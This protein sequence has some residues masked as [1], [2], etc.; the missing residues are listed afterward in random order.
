MSSAQRKT[1]TCRA[2]RRE[3]LLLSRLPM[4]WSPCGF[5]HP[6]SCRANAVFNHFGTEQLEAG[7]DG[8]AFAATLDDMTSAMKLYGQVSVAPMHVCAC[9]LLLR[10]RVRARVSVSARSFAGTS[11][12]VRVGN[13]C[14]SW[15]ASASARMYV[16]SCVCALSH[17]VFRDLRLTGEESCRTKFQTSWKPTQR[18]SQRQASPMTRPLP[19]PPSTSTLRSKIPFCVR[20]LSS[21]FRA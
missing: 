3:S 12:R 1:D 17:P 18:R 11:L 16:C 4:L 15:C 6:I 9:L 7:G 10:V 2:S 19:A 8:A 5:C 14:A 20:T 13:A 21:F